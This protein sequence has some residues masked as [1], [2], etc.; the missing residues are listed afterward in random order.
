MAAPKRPL[1]GDSANR[2]AKKSK[3]VHTSPTK[4]TEKASSKPKPKAQGGVPSMKPAFLQKSLLVAEEVNFP[5]GGGTTLTAHEVKEAREEAKREIKEAEE[6]TLKRKRKSSMKGGEVKAESAGTRVEHM[7]YKRL[8]PG[9]RLLGQITT[10]YPL[11]LILSLPNQ[12]VGYVP[13]TGISAQLTTELEKEDARFTSAAEGEDEDMEE[14]EEEEGAPEL[15]SI[16]HVGQYVQACV[17]NVRSAGTR[18]APELE[19]PK[20]EMEAMARRVELTLVPEVVNEGVVIK[21]LVKGFMLPGAIKSVEDHGYSVELGIPHLSGFLPFTNTPPSSSRLSP[22]HLLT[23]TVSEVPAS[24]RICTLTIQPSQKEEVLDQVSNVTS[25][26]PGTLVRGLITASVTSGLNLQIL[27]FFEGTIDLTHLP[28]DPA[29]YKVGTKLKARVLWHLPGSSPP[30][31]ALSALPHVVDLAAP[32]VDGVSTQEK[33]PYGEI[34]HGVKVVRVEAE[35]GLSVVLDDEETR[36][37]VHI[38][39]IS[40]EHIPALSATSGAWKVGTKHDARVLG[41]YALDGLLRLSLKPSQLERRFVQT[42]DFTPGEIVKGAIENLTD[43]GMFVDVGGDISGRVALDQL[44]DIELKHPEKRFKAGASV[45]CRILAVDPEHGRL[46]LTC[47]KSLLSSDLPIIAKLDDAK[48][49]MVADA[50]VS[51]VLPSGALVML[52]GGVKGFVPI[53]EASEGYIKSVDEILKPGQAVKVKVLSVNTEEGNILA[54]LRQAQPSYQPAAPG[55][56]V[57]DIAVGSNV[58]A[59]IK[60]VQ[61]INVVLSIQPG[62]QT[63]LLSLANLAN[64]RNTTVEALRLSLV[65]GTVLSDL[66]VVSKNPEKRIVILAVTLPGSNAG[67]SSSTAISWKTLHVG[68]ILLGQVIG[69]KNGSTSVRL[70]QYLIGR[71][72]PLDLTDN[73]EN[74]IVFPRAGSAL[75]VAVVG[76]DPHARTLDLSTRP[77]R[78]NPESH[79]PIVDPEITSLDNLQVDDKVGGVV[80]NISDSGLFVSLGRNITARVQIK[81]LFDEFVKDWQ[82][83]FSVNQ[84]VKGKITHVDHEKNRVDMSMRSGVR[85]HHKSSG[86][87]DKLRHMKDFEKRQK[88][89]GKV[90]SITKYGLFILIDDSDV[91]GLCHHSELSDTKQGDVQVAL[92]GFRVGDTVKAVILWINEETKK[93]SLGLKP[94]YFTAEDY[95]TAD[96][97][98]DQLEASKEAGESEDEDENT[99]SW[100][101]IGE[102]GKTD[103]DEDGAAS[104]LGFDDVAEEEAESE[105]DV[106]ILSGDHG[107]KSSAAPAKKSNPATTSAPTL[108]LSG[109]FQWSHT[110]DDEAEEDAPANESDVESEAS[111]SHPRK[112]KKRG[113]QIEEDLTLAMQE[114]T[115][116]SVADFERLLLGSPNSSFLWIQF[117]SFYLQLSDVDNAREIAKRALKVINFREE[118]EK[119]NV[120]IA[121]LNLEN[122]TGTE[123]SLEKTFQDATR[124]N[125]S[126]AIHLRMAT[127]FDE[128]GKP[129]KA[130][131]MHKRAVKK[132]NES[133]TVWTSFGHHYMSQGKLDEARELLPRSLKSLEKRKHI[134]TILKFA[135]ME[136]E[137]GEPERGKTLFEAIVDSHPKRLDLWFVYVD[138]EAKQ[139]DLQTV[140]KLFDRMLALKLNTFKAKSVF[141]KWL[142]LE[143]RLGDEEG[144]EHVK[145]RAVEWMQNN[146]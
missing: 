85:K 143:K 51:K 18:A 66:V 123:E 121:L 129:E 6:K 9:T 141:K 84:V 109:G 119:M 100:A 79:P 4:V 112:K 33:H 96:T 78:L 142:E 89:T 2:P 36:G 107:S 63:A 73:L 13:I 77:S 54:S 32:E 17:V 67:P 122:T 83:R 47:K 92:Q 80:K 113:H 59:E 88:V 21:D 82:T 1:E 41:F 125:D 139:G 26:L 71:L 64:R 14:R 29:L 30:K 124:A 23:C 99:T 128:S 135:Q 104:F 24:K 50:V 97:P 110:V 43:V 91:S 19:K 56:D 86:K 101:G 34:L 10:I 105:D 8:N 40:D 28:K 132:F 16:F 75:K 117:M 61:A 95:E 74:G 93:V 98:D 60:D 131:D 53:R 137:L 126:K 136:Y 134:E 20:N 140:R 69:E 5:R 55:V 114:R 70:S 35:W 130:E 111:D 57:E 144:Q 127:I 37:F 68:Q 46:T 27:G 87:E 38:A 31:F 22:G 11:H 90:T 138:M 94:S 44:A 42:G 12:L 15:A 120:W 52:Y 106:I 45:K 58:E 145:A 81:E 115:P 108:Q 146:S 102:G 76:V 103:M 116:E 48:Q 72:H 65:P 62:G 118:Q 7:N 133:T 3:P 49:G 39:N 25:L